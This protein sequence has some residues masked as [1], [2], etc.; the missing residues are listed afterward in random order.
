MGGELVVV[1]QEEAHLT[2]IRPDTKFDLGRDRAGRVATGLPIEQGR[3]GSGKAAFETRLAVATDYEAVMVVAG[4]SVEDHPKLVCGIAQKERYGGVGVEISQR[5]LAA[6][7]GNGNRSRPGDGQDQQVAGHCCAGPGSNGRTPQVRIVEGIGEEQLPETR[8]LFR[9]G[10]DGF[11]REDRRRIGRRE[12]EDGGCGRFGGRDGR[13]GQGGRGEQAAA[14]GQED[15][16]E[17]APAN[18][19]EFHRS[20]FGRNITQAVVQSNGDATT[21][22]F[23]FYCFL[24][25]TVNNNRSIYSGLQ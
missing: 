5:R 12:P 8:A 10:Q 15:E 13:G 7:A 2:A 25:K 1:V 21:F 4:S 14:S 11:G 23:S 22:I 9:G 16:Q 18:N 24:Y 3:S 17:H 20:K 19:R 6:Q